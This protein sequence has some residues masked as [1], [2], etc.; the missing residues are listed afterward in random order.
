MGR[1]ETGLD[2]ARS[3]VTFPDPTAPKELYRCDLTFLL[4]HWGCTYGRGCRGITASAPDAGCCTLGAHYTGRADE[5]RV[6]R[7]AA[8]LTPANWQ[9]H[10]SSR[11]GISTVDEGRRRTRTIDGA[12]IFL[13]RQDFPGGTGCAL[14]ALAVSTGRHPLETK[15]DVC[16]QVPIRR[17]FA[18]E[19]RPDGE[20]VM[21]TT[22]GE[23]D[24]RAWGPGGV[25]LDWW[26]TS[27]P[28]AHREAQRV[29]RS[30]AAELVAMMGEPAYRE[31]AGICER[32]AQGSIPA[33][34]PAED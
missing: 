14:H 30:C 6:R 4:S 22:I 15:P 2:F 24:R 16:W 3:W 11:R 18:W 20:R 31:L 1:A 26:C 32:A 29:Y 34:H 28:E 27:S 9:H 7:A 5:A 12:C 17:S 13:N 21:V 23:Y 10:A 33:R 8:E 19:D 25:D